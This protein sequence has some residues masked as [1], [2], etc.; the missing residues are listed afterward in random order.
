VFYAVPSFEV[1][2][3]RG[4]P[5]ITLESVSRDVFFSDCAPYLTEVTLSELKTEIESTLARIDRDGGEDNRLEIELEHLLSWAGKAGTT[6]FYYQREPPPIA[7]DGTALQLFLGAQR[8][9]LARQS[10]KTLRTRGAESTPKRARLRWLGHPFL[11]FVLVLILF[12]PA[13]MIVIGAF[14]QEWFHLGGFLAMAMLS[15][16]AARAYVHERDSGDVSSLLLKVRVGL[17]TLTILSAF[18]TLFLLVSAI[19]RFLAR[20]Q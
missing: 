9:Q 20:P 15:M 19:A 6:N 17:L 11:H 10:A 5:S 13:T 7:G 2:P 4:T 14:G 18:V 8:R 1:V 12:A 16:S 3:E